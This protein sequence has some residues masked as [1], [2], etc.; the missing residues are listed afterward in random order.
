EVDPQTA[1]FPKPQPFAPPPLPPI[2]IQPFPAPPGAA[3]LPIQGGKNPKAF[4]VLPA[5]VPPPAPMPAA[6]PAIQDQIIIN[7]QPVPVPIAPGGPARVIQPIGWASNN[8]GNDRIILTDGKPQ[9][10]PTCYAGA[11][12]IRALP[13]S[14][15]PARPVAKGDAVAVLEVVA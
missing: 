5:P 12:R 6:A 4:N 3:P 11:V 2:K 1:G 9:D 7:G 8:G 15:A 13:P 10:L 14:A